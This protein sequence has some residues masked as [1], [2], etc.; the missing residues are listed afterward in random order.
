MMPI[1]AAAVLIAY[2]LLSIEIYLA[3]YCVGRFEMSRWGIGPTELRILLAIGTL[4]LFVKPVVTMAGGRMGLFDAGGLIA[5]AGMTVT[6]L[7]AMLG[8]IR[9]LY[10]AEPLPQAVHETQ[11]RRVQKDPPYLRCST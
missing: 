1:I 5:A 7:V 10:R 11:H 3:T 8:H 9:A 2:Y 4:M 6:A